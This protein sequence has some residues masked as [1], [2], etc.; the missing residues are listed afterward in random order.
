MKVCIGNS[1]GASLALLLGVLMRDA[2]IVEVQT[3]S[4]RPGPQIPDI[5]G[6]GVKEAHERTYGPPKKTRKGK[7]RKW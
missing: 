6:W 5:T 3:I 2:E 1:A 7:V 4:L